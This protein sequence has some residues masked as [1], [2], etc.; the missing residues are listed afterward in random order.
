M[1]TLE[2]P[3]GVRYERQFLVVDER[4]GSLRDGDT[5]EL[6]P[7]QSAPALATDR[8]AANEVVLALL[9]HVENKQDRNAAAL[10]RLVERNRTGRRLLGIAHG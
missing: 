7:L 1:L 2:N 5:G 3:L 6:I 8:V 10:H 4:P 9:D